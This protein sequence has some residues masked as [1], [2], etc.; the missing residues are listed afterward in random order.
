MRQIPL[1]IGV[2]AARTFDQFLPGANAAALAHLT[3]LR[4]PAAPVYLWGPSGSGK[5]H[6]L[7]ALVRRLERAGG[8]AGWFGAALPVPWAHD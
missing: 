2:E 7:Q 4:A 1:A 5:T 6:L 8:H 3:T